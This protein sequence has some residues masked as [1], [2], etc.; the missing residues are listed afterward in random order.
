MIQLHERE[1]QISLGLQEFVYG[2]DKL[3]VTLSK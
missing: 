2:A 3:F 1:I